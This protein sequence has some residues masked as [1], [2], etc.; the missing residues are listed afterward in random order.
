VVDVATGTGAA[1]EVVGPAGEVIA[2]DISSAMLDVE[3]HN[4]KNSVV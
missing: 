1:A 2:G 4:I 3:R